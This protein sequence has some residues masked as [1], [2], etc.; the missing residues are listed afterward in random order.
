MHLSDAGKGMTKHKHQVH[1]LRV[2][3]VGFVAFRAYVTE[4]ELLGKPA[5]DTVF[6]KVKGSY[7]GRREKFLLPP[8]CYITICAARPM[9][10]PFLSY[11]LCVCKTEDKMHPLPLSCLMTDMLI[12]LCPYSSCKR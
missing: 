2:S 7:E 11:I 3:H 1:M 4:E 6:E 10:T 9:L 12:R 8:P 5:P